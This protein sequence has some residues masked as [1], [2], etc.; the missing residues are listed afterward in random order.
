MPQTSIQKHSNSICL[1]LTPKDCLFN[2]KE[3]M[4]V[5]ESNFKATKLLHYEKNYHLSCY[6]LQ[7]TV[8]IATKAFGFLT[9]YLKDDT[10]AKNKIKHNAYLFLNFFGDSVTNPNSLSQTQYFHYSLLMDVIIQYISIT[11]GKETGINVE[12]YFTELM[13]D[14][15][16]KQILKMGYKYLLNLPKEI[17]SSEKYVEWVS[18]MNQLEK[19]LSIVKSGLFGLENNPSI[20]E[21]PEYLDIMSELV[22][23][24][25]F[26]DKLYLNINEEGKAKLR[27]LIQRECQN[28]L[29]PERFIPVSKTYVYLLF[30]IEYIKYLGVIT[31]HLESRTRYP[32]SYKKKGKSLLSNPIDEFNSKNSI[33][34]VFDSLIT[35]TERFLGLISELIDT[36]NN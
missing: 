28:Y 8:E 5:A 14:N 29:N 3:W 27:E 22:E 1:N 31:H 18:C 24:E 30:I 6:H 21:N 36:C 20:L 4:R 16:I 25:I 26:N 9:G 2:A 17:P 33:I 32:S 23:D 11:L 35:H 15:D 13:K 19:H 12:N 7:Q 10:D 34:Q